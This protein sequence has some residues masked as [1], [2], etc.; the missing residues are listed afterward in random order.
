[1]HLTQSQSSLSRFG[2]RAIIQQSRSF[3]N[4]LQSPKT[5]NAEFQ[6][7]LHHAVHLVK[8]HDP[9]GFLPGRLLPSPEMQVAY[10]AVRGFWVETGLRFGSTAKVSPNS[11]PADHL[12]W[13]KQGIEE[14]YNDEQKSELPKDFNHPTLRLLKYLLQEEAQ[15]T[16]CHFDDI[17]LGRSRDLDL[18]QY[19]DLQSLK[20]HAVLSCGS[21]SQLVLES[22]GLFQQDHALAHAAAKQVGTSHGLTNALRTSIPVISTTG[23]LI[24][25]QD[26]CV[27]YDVKSPRYLLSALGQGD[28]KCIQALRNAVQDICEVA[29]EHLQ[30]ARSQR[31]DIIAQSGNEA[32]SVLL[33]GLAS[34]T[35]LNRLQ[36][37]NFD[38]TNRDLRHVSAL[39]HAKCAGKMIVASY[40][41]KF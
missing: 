31:Q 39:E 1:M 18:K 9:A 13:W 24:I 11:T 10:Y 28:V 34:E 2:K 38:L 30:T 40:Q 26:L 27:K 8:S 17:I 5:K 7:D 22:Q 3:M 21:L 36:Q 19:P 12:A 6:Q 32:V 35:F 25:P 4:L 23:K 29:R 37:F 16:K 33:P 20:D 41:H 15:F 14:L